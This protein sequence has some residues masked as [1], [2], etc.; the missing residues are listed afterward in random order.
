MA[1]LN[2]WFG[3]SEMLLAE[4]FMCFSVC[5]LWFAGH[6]NERSGA[7]QPFPCSAVQS[8]SSLFFLWISLHPPSLKYYFLVNMCSIPMYWHSL[9][10]AVSDVDLTPHC[11][12]LKEL[13]SN[14]SPSNLLGCAAKHINRL[15]HAI[16]AGLFFNKLNSRLRHMIHGHGN[17]LCVVD[18]N[19]AVCLGEYMWMNG[20]GFNHT[21][22]KKM[23]WL[24][25]SKGSCT[26]I[27]YLPQ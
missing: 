22:E 24:F 8:Q 14:I 25:I 17:V 13:L 11:T 5:L 1:A 20:C 23:M 27:A 7:G 6:K 21:G 19:L 12:Y 18:G 10:H 9:K 2:H 26:T 3:T 16:S 4:W 15:S